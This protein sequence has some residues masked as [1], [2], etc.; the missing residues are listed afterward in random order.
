M[1]MGAAGAA[2]ATVAAQGLSVA[3]AFFRM[4]RVGFG[5]KIEK[6]EFHAAKAETI[7][8]LK[9]GLPIAAQEAL[10]GV[11]F[12][13]ILAI[14]NGFGLVA[15][16]GVGV[17]EKICALMFLV[18][19]TVMSAVSAFSAQNVGA[20]LYERA[21]KAMYFGMGFSFVI[22]MVVF[23][24]SFFH[25]DLLAGLF[26]SDADVIAA[27]ADYLR[28]YSLDIVI[29]GFNFSM[30]GYLNGCGKTGFVAL[31]GILSTFLVRI[32]VSYF[33][34]KMPHVTLF[35]VG[36]ATPMATVFAI[37]ITAAYLVWQE[38]KRRG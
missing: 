12:M 1:K 13:V 33:M 38:K 19:G 17:A 32:P 25:G 9:Y 26:T 6:A 5:I 22:G 18:P 8:I 23:L 29:V 34:S 27:A 4:K 14:L 30:M 37:V 15:S 35:Q 10:T 3:C 21:R 31:Q 2:V 36:F 20:G 11:S 7:D 16:A 28:S 24:F